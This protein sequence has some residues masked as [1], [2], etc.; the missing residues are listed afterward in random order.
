MHSLLRCSALI[1]ALSSR[2]GAALRWL[3]LA[4]CLISA[5]NAFT[6]KFFDLSSNAW[7]ELQWYLFGAIVMLAAAYTLQRNEHVRVDLIYSHVSA[8]AQ[9]WIDL[10]GTLIFLLPVAGLLTWL[11]W[12]MFTEA[13]RIGETSANAGGLPRW[14]VKLVLPVGF[15][16]L[17]LQGLSE[18]IKCAAALTGHREISPAH[19]ERPLQ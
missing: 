2:L 1:D 13:W 4:A 17:F 15:A 18:L 16:L 14:P 6:R 11:S 3:V 8:R 19:Y 12:P 7:L 9:L 5:G 10:A